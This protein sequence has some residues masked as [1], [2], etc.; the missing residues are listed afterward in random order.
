[1]KMKMERSDAVAYLRRKDKIDSEADEFTAEEEKEI[2]KVMTR[3]KVYGDPCV[4][5]D[6][7]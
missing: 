2:E 6:W 7:K 1:M 4:E 3:G 5:V